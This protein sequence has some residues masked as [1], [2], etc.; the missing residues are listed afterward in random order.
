MSYGSMHIA[1]VKKNSRIPEYWGLVCMRGLFSYYEVTQVLFIEM[2]ILG[3]CCLD[4]Y[5]IEVGKVQA[6]KILIWVY[7]MSSGCLSAAML[8]TPRDSNK[9]EN[10]KPPKT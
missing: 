2:E 4:D 7:L 9:K 3:K 5:C 6:K 8:T 10:E 1:I